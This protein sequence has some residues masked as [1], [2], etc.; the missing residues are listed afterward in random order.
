MIDASHDIPALGAPQRMTWF[1]RLLNSS[2]GRK[3]LVAVT[4]L[5]LCGFL[6]THL[7]G[8]L[9][10]FKGPETFNAYA[11]SLAGNPLIVPMEVGLALLFLAHI[12]L[13]A[14][15]TIRNRAAR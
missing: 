7:A 10:L 14:V 3:Q 13:A 1:I 8:N 6:V 9:L 12:V 5:L 2:I 4:G 15:V 11:A